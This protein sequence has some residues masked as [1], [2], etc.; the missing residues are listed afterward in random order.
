M[1]LDGSRRPRHRTFTVPAS[2]ELPRELTRPTADCRTNIQAW[3]SYTYTELAELKKA[4]PEVYEQLR[5]DY[6]K[7]KAA[8]KV[9][10]G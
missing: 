9:K 3:E 6:L 7:R 10:R 1:P 4:Q 5:A 8:G 2:G